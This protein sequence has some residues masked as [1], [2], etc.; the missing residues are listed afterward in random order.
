MQDFEYRINLR[1]LRVGRPMIEGPECKLHDI[2]GG[3]AG[4]VFITIHIPGTSYWAGM[5]MRGFDPATLQVHKIQKRNL[6][7]EDN[8][9]TFRSSLTGSINIPIR[10]SVEDKEELIKRLCNE[11]E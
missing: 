3:G 11:I 8:F 6:K 2:A 5:G 10:P 7:R 1:T 9:L 4:V